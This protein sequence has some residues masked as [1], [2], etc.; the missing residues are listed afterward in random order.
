ME[1]FKSVND[2]A[3]LTQT[4][5]DAFI[6][7]N[8]DDF[9]DP[10]PQIFYRGPKVVVDYS[11]STWG[12]WLDNPTIHDPN[13]KIAKIFM[14]RFRVPFILFDQKIKK[15]CIENNVFE[16]TYESKATVPIEFKILLALRLLGRGNCYDDINELSQVPASSVPYYFHKFVSNFSRLFYD[17]FIRFPGESSLQ[18]RLDH[19][20]ALGL[21]GAMGSVDCTRIH[22]DKCPKYLTN[23]CIGKEGFPALSFLLVCDHN[24]QIVHVSQNAYLGALNDINICKIFD[25]PVCLPAFKKNG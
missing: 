13:S 12:R 25:S 22:W 1:K 23:F 10:D 3:N 21:P 15:M 4:L 19:Y 24:R 16:M 18:D 7:E 11:S 9:V 8:M 6:S 2:D 14:L 20:A 5:L 17:E